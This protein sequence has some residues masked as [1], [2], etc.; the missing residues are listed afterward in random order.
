[1]KNNKTINQYKIGNK[2]DMEQ[3]VEDY[4]K[5]LFKV[6]NN[7]GNFL[8]QDDIEEVL[9]ETFFILWT[10]SAKLEDNRP[11][12]PYLVGIL[13]KLVFRKKLNNHNIF[14]IEDYEYVL[15]SL[16]DINI[17]YERNEINCIL[18]NE[19][20]LFSQNDR[21]IFELYYYNNKKTKEIA[22]IL[23]MKDSNVRNRL[24]RIRKKLCKRLEE[25]GYG[26][27]L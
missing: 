17:T 14:N 25:K 19:I 12:L 1:M 11:I 3:I 10:N 13:K 2:L 22:K 26:S 4:S 16:D 8:K 18:Y 27:R 23:N 24:H 5:Y 15:P 21:N 9:Y 6:A 20:K 7:I